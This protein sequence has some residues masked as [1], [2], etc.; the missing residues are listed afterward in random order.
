M[1][2]IYSGKVSLKSFTKKVFPFSVYFSVA[3]EKNKYSVFRLFI[4]SGK[5]ISPLGT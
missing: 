5:L 1:K 3:D 2:N 4:Q